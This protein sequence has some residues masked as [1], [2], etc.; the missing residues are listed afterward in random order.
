M[1]TMKNFAAL[2]LAGTLAALTAPA[3]VHAADNGQ[4]TKVTFPAFDDGKYIHGPKITA[5]DL[6]GK[7]VFFEYWGI[8]CPPCIASM[9]HLQELQD[10]YQS[11]GFTVVGSHRQ[12]L[13][14]RVKQF[15]QEKNITF[16]VYQGLDIPA[17]SCPGGLPHA[18]LIGASGK[19]VA[20]GYP[21][22]L[23]DLV[24]KEVLKAE[25]GYPILEGV[26]LNKYKSL[27]RAV[28]SNGSNIESKITP[29]R[30]KTDDEEAQAVCAAFDDWLEE[31]KDM[32]QSRIRTNPLEAVTAI[33]RLKTAVPSVKEFDAALAELKANK[34]L[35]R[36]ADLNKKI[37]VLEQR[38][39]KGRK[40]AE[41][42]LNSLTQAVDKFT[43][44]G[45]DATQTIAANLKKT[46][47]ALA[48]PASKDK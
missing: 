13:T 20:K 7:V 39:A 33:T 14:P 35:P 16:P 36:L 41:A 44:S 1:G 2:F 23:Y 47:S 45:N 42:D 30:N 34:D 3:H 28:V 22:E 9:P 43:E 17:A 40:V 21:P 46:L 27:A 25:R 12:G 24:K 18:V 26:E 37:S 38:K 5:S 8:N 6:K 48:G 10:K 15:L 11:K 19:V 31:T 4:G 29:L 32:V